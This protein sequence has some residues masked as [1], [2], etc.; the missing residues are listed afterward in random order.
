MSENLLEIE[1][2]A[3]DAKVSPDSAKGI[4]HLQAYVLVFRKD[5][6]VRKVR[7]SGH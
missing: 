3:G 1:N 2:L 4:N 7:C 5:K 6:C